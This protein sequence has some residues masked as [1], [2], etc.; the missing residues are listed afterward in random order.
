MSADKSKVMI[1]S[2]LNTTQDRDKIEIDSSTLEE[3][4]TFQYL[5]VTL[6]EEINSE[7]EIKKRLAVATNQLSK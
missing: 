1:A 5:R 3:V 7:N 6:N 4:K 2:Q